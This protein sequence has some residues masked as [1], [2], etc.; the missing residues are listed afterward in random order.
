MNRDS[1]PEQPSGY[2][3][4]IENLVPAESVNQLKPLLKKYLGCLN[5]RLALKTI[6]EVY[7]EVNQNELILH[8]E[9]HNG[10][11]LHYV[12][13]GCLVHK[14][15]NIFY[16]LD[17][18]ERK[19]FLEIFRIFYNKKNSYTVTDQRLLCVLESNVE[20]ATLNL[21]SEYSLYM[22]DLSNCLFNCTL[23]HFDYF[24]FDDYLTLQNMVI[25]R[26]DSI[27]RCEAEDSIINFYL[28]NIYKL[29]HYTDYYF[30][31]LVYISIVDRLINV[32]DNLF[33][34]NYNKYMNLFQHIYNDNMR[35][36][37][38]PE[39]ENGKR[40]INNL[41]FA[42][43][44]TIFIIRY[45]MC[46]NKKSKLFRLFNTLRIIWSIKVKNKNIKLNIVNNEIFSEYARLSVSDCYILL[47][48]LVVKISAKPQV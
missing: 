33:I 42:N 4:N 43:I 41:F 29:H 17:F 11:S 3:I 6:Y 16:L 38:D 28:I 40:N 18:D 21:F 8:F 25:L 48:I 30:L 14:M 23:N 37:G 7:E 39:Y 24:M 19:R 35:L 26:F 15:R 27:L 5:S 2:I 47:K 1:E 9:L 46:T 44:K 20:V 34:L 22:L 31:Y 12:I 45:L 36:L 13:C 32:H 10:L